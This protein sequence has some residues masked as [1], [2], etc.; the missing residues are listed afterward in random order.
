MRKQAL[1][2][3]LL[4]NSLLLFAG[5][6]IP[7]YGKID[8]SDLQLKECEFDKDAEACNLISYGDV[9]YTI[10]GE[11]F[12]IITERRIRIKI[13]KE[14]GLDEANIKIRFY[15]RSNY[16]NINSISGLTYNL[17]NSG[18]IVITKL[19]KS[20]VY[21]KAIDKQYSEV[22]FTLPDVKIGSVIEYK[23]TDV[24]KS[25]DNLDDWYFQDDI[26]T[27]F[28]EYK[29]LVPSIFKF[30][31]QLL[32]YQNVEQKDDNL[33]QTAVYDN[34]VINFNSVSK[35][36]ILRNIPAIRDE[37]YMGA[38]RDYLQR[39][40]FQLSQIDFGDG[41]VRDIR[42]SW[43]KLSKELL[44]DDDFGLQL[45]KNIP[46]TKG[47]DDSLK[48]VQDDY[49]KMVLIHDYVRR[50]M[51][52]NGSESIYSMDGVKSAWDKKSGNNTEIN[53]ILI[54]LLRDA[55][56]KAYPLL[57]STKDNGEVNVLYPFLQQF[58]NTMAAVVIGDKR[59]I[60]NAADK[61][62]PAY[63]IPYDVLNSEGFVVD[64]N[65]GSWI[66]LTDDK[67]AF[68]NNVSFI[69]E[70]T[71]QDSMTGSVTIYNYDYSKNINVKKWIEDKSNFTDSYTQYYSGMQINNLKVSGL[72]EDTKPLTQKFNFSMPV[73]SS[74][75]Y[76]YFTLNLFQGL[77]KNPF[78]ADQRTTDIEFNYKQS[79]TI[80]GKIFIPD[81]YQF[82]DLPQN[83]K[84]IMPDSSIILT[85]LLQSGAGSLDFRITL[86]FTKSTYGAK[87]YPF[88]QEFYKKLYSI[89]NEQ[90]VIK[91]KTNSQ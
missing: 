61:Y 24:K 59:Y 30:T 14:K 72:N 81:N 53:L 65:N 16:E 87:E 39:V 19:G 82:D 37:P 69:A 90:I 25:I 31:T 71:P 78:I 49:S 58:N 32:A 47:L 45:K 76:E 11:D 2:I 63:L 1:T 75:D 88:L 22:S 13:L 27:R 68:K 42:S 43:P 21:I 86:D 18:N 51:N 60:L 54:N 91:K 56:L 89:L 83:L 64:E 28:S 85:R 7:A 8:K 6:E 38:P 48:N 52:W 62:N 79:Y 66:N 73:K 40:I 20:S 12:N 15:S 3:L 70:I 46:H 80:T 67:D 4:F 10:S 57:V 50:N 55:G 84:M 36:Y 44:D 77:E 41:V 17:D 23:Y 5:K 26:P 35:T 29:I 34:Q 74:G 33:P 9:H